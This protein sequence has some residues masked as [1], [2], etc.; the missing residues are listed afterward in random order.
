MVEAKGM[1][2]CLKAAVACGVALMVV[3]A[4]VSFADAGGVIDWKAKVTNSSGHNVKVLPYY[5]VGGKEMKEQVINNGDS[6][7][8]E[9][10]NKCP[11][12][13][14]GWVYDVSVSMA[15]RCAAGILAG[16]CTIACYDT[17]WKITKHTDGAYHFD[18]N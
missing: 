9:T 16:A 18:K 13:L 10:V 1:K 6:Y 11:F 12:L 7:T 5:D 2:R 15:E 3:V 4:M 14:A 17:E 8:F